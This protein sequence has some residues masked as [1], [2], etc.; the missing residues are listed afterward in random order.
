MAVL[1]GKLDGIEEKVQYLSHVVRDGNGEKSIITRLALLEKDLS[2]LEKELEE[3]TKD[4]KEMEKSLHERV[5]G[6]KNLVNQ[7]KKTEA[8]FKR[9]KTLG[10]LKLVA[11]IVPG[12]LAL[13]LVLAKF[14][15]GE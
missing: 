9:E 2:D 6:V 3:H 15:L 12:L 14:F 7:D 13:G 8:E 11:T 10:F 4:D 5:S 1:K